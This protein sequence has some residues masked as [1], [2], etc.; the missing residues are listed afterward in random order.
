M[1]PQPPGI[2]DVPGAK[3]AMKGVGKTV[4]GSVETVRALTSSVVSAWRNS[5]DLVCNF[6]ALHFL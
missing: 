3:G 4:G 6:F 5:F 1:A 2:N